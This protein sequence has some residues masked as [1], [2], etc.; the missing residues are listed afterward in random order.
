MDATDVSLSQV[1]PSSALTQKLRMRSLQIKFIETLPRSYI[2]FCLLILQN[3]KSSLLKQ[4]QP[5]VFTSQLAYLRLFNTTFVIYNPHKCA[6]GVS[7][8]NVWQTIKSPVTTVCLPVW[9]F[10]TWICLIF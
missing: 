5:A 4:T 8:Q 1:T 9:Y 10:L 6:D 7:S 2:L 3:R